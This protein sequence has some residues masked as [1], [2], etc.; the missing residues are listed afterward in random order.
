MVRR[1]WWDEYFE[2][3]KRG[4]TFW[5]EVLGGLTTFLVSAYIIFVNPAI[6]SFSGIKDLQPLG[7]PFGPALAV[8]CLTAGVMTLVMALYA[9]Y[10]FMMAPGMGL[11]AVV[12]YTLIVQMKLTWQEAMGVIL[13]EGV[14]ITVLVLTGF[15][16]AVMEAIPMSLKRSIAVGIGLFIAFIGFV[17]CGFVVLGVPSAP[18]ALGK[19]A[20]PM[21]AV[22]VVG[23]L[24]MAGLEARKVKGSLLWGIL[25]ST[26]FAIAL[27]SWLGGTVY[28][29]LPGVA[30]VP[31]Q[32]VSTPDFSNLGQGLNLGVFAKVGLVSALLTIFSI[33]L[34]DFFD[35]MG[36]LVG[37]GEQAGFLS[38]RDN[39]PPSATWRLLLTDSLGA[40]F[41]GFAGA[42]SN[43]TYIESGAGV[44]EGART[45]LA[46]VVTGVLFLLCMVLAPVAGVIPPQATGP[47]LIIVG[48]IM[49]R[50]NIS[51]IVKSIPADPGDAIVEGLPILMTM[52]VMPITYSITNG[53]GVGFVTYVVLKTF[54]GQARQV[55]WMMWLVSAAFV[56]YFITR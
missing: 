26:V 4:S 35:T 18:V 52:L 44:S 33:G 6:L 43:T 39:Y 46:S 34:S 19:V 13:L 48:W 53:I 27:N 55:H 1:P 54:K 7:V 22:A 14:F 50:A 56:L 51:E 24:A 29:D 15:R 31:S 2:V 28:A 23:F 47:A 8:T 40:V 45:G 5:T 17:N 21:M 25:F 32:W 42:S 49:L 36:T 3:T 37:V 41:G 38:D 11:N 20:T 9:K 30:V 16:Q 10:P 12:A